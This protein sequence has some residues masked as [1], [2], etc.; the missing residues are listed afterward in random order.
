MVSLDG[1]RESHY[2]CCRGS[3]ID[4]GQVFPA[5]RWHLRTNHALPRYRA[6]KQS[7]TVAVDEFLRIQFTLNRTEDRELCEE[8]SA[9]HAKA[10][11]RR[12]R[13]LLRAGS[14]A[15]R[16][17]LPPGV[18]TRQTAHRTAQVLPEP[19]RATNSEDVGRISGVE[20]SDRYDA[21]DLDSG[22]FNFTQNDSA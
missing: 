13:A 6:R 19:H 1:R 9:L 16:G 5:L 18:A 17:E 15:F 2:R 4:H 14:A 20:S 21:F 10:R 22:Q 12:I 3:G 8:F 11:A 7:G